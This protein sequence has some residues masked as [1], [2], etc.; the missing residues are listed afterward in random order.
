MARRWPE[1][2]A[3]R[4]ALAWLEGAHTEIEKRALK[5]AL[6]REAEYR[7]RMSQQQRD[8]V[9]ALAAEI[10]GAR[11]HAAEL[12]DA[13]ESRAAGRNAR[14]TQQHAVALVYAERAFQLE[15]DAYSGLFL[16]ST[17]RRVGQLDAALDRY[18]SLWAARSARHRVIT[19]AAAVLADQGKFA[20]AWDLLEPQLSQRDDAHAF[21]LAGRLRRLLGD[22]SSAERYL[23]R[24][25][26]E[27]CGPSG[28]ASIRRDVHELAR[29]A[30][31]AGDTSVA[32]AA[33]GLRV[34]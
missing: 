12:V 26:T 31:E 18:R 24:A 3:G 5:A 19:G 23:R 17:Q 11:K 7:A 16:A 13:A 22:L 33:Q 8:A 15:P 29:Q 2:S 10:A 6:A 9:Q 14:Q 27:P 4:D 30:R 20:E 25:L 32:A 34:S 28:P 21:A 1:S